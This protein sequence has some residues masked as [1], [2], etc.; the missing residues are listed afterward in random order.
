MPLFDAEVQRTI[1]CTVPV[2]AASPEDA[3]E[4]V[5]GS[6]FPLPAQGEWQTL[7]G[8]HISI[9]HP[10]SEEELLQEDT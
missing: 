6:S 4:K 5:K 9:V 1:Y 10:A 2:E 8:E 3:M 7:K